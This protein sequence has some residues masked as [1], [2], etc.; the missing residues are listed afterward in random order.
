MRLTLDQN[1]PVPLVNAMAPFMPST[2]ELAHVHK[3]DPHFSR[4]GD[5]DLVVA[6]ANGGTQCLVTTDYHMLDDPSTVSALVATKL[7]LFVVESAGHG[8]LRASG[9]L[10]LE[11]PGIERR[12]AGNE[13]MVIYLLRYRPKSPRPAWE[14]LKGIA[15][16]H[17]STA[18]ELFRE[19]RPSF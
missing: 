11:L 2:L 17:G 18:S 19:S 7:N 8:P 16:K 9:A 6:L 4:L 1:F 5:A 14:H 13:A 3:L 10:F 15:A 12:L